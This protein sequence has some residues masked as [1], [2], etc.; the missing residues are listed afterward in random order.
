[1][2]TSL[3]FTAVTQSILHMSGRHVSMV[4]SFLQSFIVPETAQ[5]LNEYCELVR[6][7]ISSSQN[8]E[9]MEAQEA[10]QNRLEQI[11]TIPDNIN[12]H[13]KTEKSEG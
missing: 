10:L 9:K 12:I 2:V 7:S 6:S 1:M 5:I 4:L 13:L 3:L 8:N 11:K